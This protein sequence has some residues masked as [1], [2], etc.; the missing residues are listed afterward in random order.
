VPFIKEDRLFADDIKALHQ[1]VKD[2]ELLEIAEEAAIKN[3]IKL[4]NNDEFGIY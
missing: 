2:G 1:L 4:D 3:N